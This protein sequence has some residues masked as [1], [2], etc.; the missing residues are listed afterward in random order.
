MT[1]LMAEA[2]PLIKCFK[3]KE[4]I[5]KGFRLFKNGPILLIVSGVGK[6]AA[7]SACSF[8]FGKY[9]NIFALLNV[10]IA[11]SKNLPIGYPLI[12]HKII[13]KMTKKNFY[14]TFTFSPLLPSH[15]IITVGAI[16]KDYESV[17][18]MESSSICEITAKF[19]SFEL[20][21]F[22]KIISDNSCE[23][24]SNLT[25]EKIFKLIEE[26]YQSIKV[27]AEELLKFEKEEKSSLPNLNCHLSVSE[28]YRL[29]DLLRRLH[30][31]QETVDL[32]CCKSAKEIFSIVEEKIKNA[33]IVL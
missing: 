18:D 23:E 19:I 16:E 5:C 26:N 2:L 6:V 29:K 7:A 31:L 15:E 1:A 3:L 20:M 11:G 13:D 27:V 30:S 33:S 25:K 24:A 4:E 28:K 8:A 14:P 22:I 12:A 10:G 17:Q 21:H 32:S 9:A